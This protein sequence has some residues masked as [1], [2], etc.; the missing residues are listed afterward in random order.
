MK[1][2]ISL[3][4]MTLMIFSLVGCMDNPDSSEQRLGKDKT[5]QSDWSYNDDRKRVSKNN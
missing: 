4:A 5:G 3:L 1:K 2:L